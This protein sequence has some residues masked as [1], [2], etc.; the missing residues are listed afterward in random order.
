MK[1]A[2]M[3][4]MAILLGARPC[5]ANGP[6]VGFDAGTIF[7]L[8]SQ[9]IQL[10]SESVDIR[11]TRASRLPSSRMK[12]NALCRYV[13]RNL[14]DSTCVFRMAFVGGSPPAS[15]DSSEANRLN[16]ENEFEVLQDGQPRG[17]AFYPSRGDEF[18]KFHS[19]Q[20]LFPTWTV[21]LAALATSVIEMRYDASWTGGG[22]DDGLCGDEFRYCTQPAALWAGKIESAEFHL[23]MP[24][25][26]FLR[27]LQRERDEVP[28]RVR[29]TPWGYRWTSDGLIW[30]FKDW[31]PDND[32]RLTLEYMSVGSGGDP[33]WDPWT[34][35]SLA[36]LPAKTQG[37]DRGPQLETNRGC[38]DPRQFIKPRPAATIH[39]RVHVTEQGL[40]DQVRYLGRRNDLLT[41]APG[42]C[43]M[44][45][46]FR[47]AVKSGIA[48]PAWTDVVVRYPEAK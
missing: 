45:W 43:A 34:P 14:S 27:N 10:V 31:E 17:V 12:H 19:K 47:P 37:L 1:W 11:L 41:N 25:A 23:H 4:I 6:E 32:L 20:T 48:V 28:W 18:S 22:C 13:L 15:V 7:P 3:G 8:E 44:S 9:N 46:L 16:L 35:D 42:L 21:S 24:D 26:D 29:V 5:Q 40:V 33:S 36:A 2:A 38:D 39:L 30:Q